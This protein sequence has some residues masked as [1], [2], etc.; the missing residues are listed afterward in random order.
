[1]GIEYGLRV[2]PPGRFKEVLRSLAAY[3][4]QI[5]EVDLS[6][7]NFSSEAD[8]KRLVDYIL[9]CGGVQTVNLTECQLKGPGFTAL[10]PLMQV[11]AAVRCVIVYNTEC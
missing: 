9:K 6:T 11:G 10:A 7:H 1:M 2:V 3:P 4:G 5:Q 8:V